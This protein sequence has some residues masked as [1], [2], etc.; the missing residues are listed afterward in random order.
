LILSK[1]D[2]L[3]RNFLKRSINYVHIGEIL[4][5]NKIIKNN[6]FAFKISFGITRNDDEI[7]P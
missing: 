1:R 5:Q 2:F 4:D 6:V 3:K 7:E